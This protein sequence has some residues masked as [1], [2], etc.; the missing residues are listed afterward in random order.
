VQSTSGGAPVPI[1]PYLPKAEYFYSGQSQ[2]GSLVLFETR[3]KLTLE[4][5]EG[6]P[7]LYAWERAT[8]EIALA[9]VRNDETSPPKG[10]IA[11]SYEWTEGI[12]PTSLR[13]GGSLRGFYLQ[14]EHA[15]T[16]DGSVYFTEAGTGHLYRRLNPAAEQSP[17]DGEDNC[18]DPAKACTIH[19]S[20]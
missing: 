17:L 7:N 12:T 18:E 11:G 20:A 1:T 4:A 5:L 16:P 14:D 3:S 13:L 9:G 6:F 8:G 10:T 15:I 19:I 2:D